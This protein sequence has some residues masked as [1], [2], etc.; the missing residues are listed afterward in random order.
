MNKRPRV[1]FTIPLSRV[2][3]MT[4][5]KFL[6]NSSNNYPHLHCELPRFLWVSSLRRAAILRGRGRG[7]HTYPVRG[8][9]FLISKNCVPV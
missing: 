9:L 4:P 3:L 2:L 5:M 1:P 6:E 8:L 7:T